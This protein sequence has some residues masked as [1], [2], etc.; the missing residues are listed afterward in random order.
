M[1]PFIYENLLRRILNL[2][3]DAAGLY[4][5]D[6]VPIWLYAVIHLAWWSLGMVIVIAMYPLVLFAQIRE[7]KSQSRQ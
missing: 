2:M 5:E 3:K 7:T 1:N 6:R 4:E